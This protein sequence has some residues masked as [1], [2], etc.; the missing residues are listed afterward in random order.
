MIYFQDFKK[1]N[2][3]EFFYHYSTDTL[4]PG[5]IIYSH[6]DR[7]KTY[8]IVWRQYAYVYNQM[9]S[10]EFPHKY[11]YAYP[12]KKDRNMKGYIVKP[13]AE[14]IFGN[15]NHS[16]YFTMDHLGSFVDKSIPLKDRL[17]LRDEKLKEEAVKYFT[18]IEYPQYVEAICEK[19]V[20]VKS[21]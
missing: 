21:I 2:T 12:E 16:V 1:F 18:L 5:E 8:D 14:V 15:Y 7:M 20:I 11:G 6:Q 17:I 4:L 10:K 13:E 9:F 3:P 19:F